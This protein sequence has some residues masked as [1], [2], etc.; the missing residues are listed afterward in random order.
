MKPFREFDL[1]LCPSLLLP[2]HSKL[3]RRD[4]LLHIQFVLFNTRE[5]SFHAPN[6]T[7]NDYDTKDCVSVRVFSFNHNPIDGFP[8]F[9][10]SKSARYYYRTCQS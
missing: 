3:Q 9:R 1:I 4:F 10:D 6:H 2:G 7:F 5:L 8:E